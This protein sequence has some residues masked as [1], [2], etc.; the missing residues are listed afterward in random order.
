MSTATSTKKLLLVSDLDGTLLDSRKRVTPRTVDVVN[1]FVAAGGL[2]SIATA[3][4]PHGCRDRLAELDLRVPSVV[5]N[6]AALYSFADARYEHAFTLADDHVNHVAE[7]V[8]DLGA[9]AFVYAIADGRLRIGYRSEADLQWTQYNSEAARAELGS[10]AVLGPSDWSR[11]GDVVYVAVVG[12]DDRLGAVGAAVEGA[13]GVRSLPYRNVYTET[14]CLEIAASGAG[15]ENALRVL[16]STVGADAL[17]AFGDN[18]NDVGMMEMADVSY[19]PDNAVPE[20]RDLA[21]EVIPSND[22]DGVAEAVDRHYM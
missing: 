12:G 1:R 10:F 9:G 17:I 11:L 3:R 5:M 14:D 8:A 22:A 20:I 18:Y 4:M 16:M 15:K 21:D 2:F 7:I 19:A 13:P 6:G